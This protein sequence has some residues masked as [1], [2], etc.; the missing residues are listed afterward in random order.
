[1]KKLLLGLSCLLL[2]AM[3]QLA[4]A[5]P[6]AFDFLG[7]AMI[8]A[9]VGGSLSMY[10][11]VQEGSSTVVPP[12]PLDFINF[13][14]TIVVTDLVL[15]TDGTVQYYSNGA[16]ALYEDNGTV[17]DYANLATF[18]DG[19]PILTGVITTLSRSVTT[20]IFPPFATTITINGTVDWTGGTRLNEMAPAD[21]LNWSFLSAGNNDPADVMPGFTEQW[22][23]KVEPKEPIVGSDDSSF[24]DLKAGYQQ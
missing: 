20:A 5:Q 22:D 16:I 13:D 4:S 3:P 6:Q 1:M 12:L 19:T 10:S 7:Q 14:Y 8:P 2:I 17:A 21:Q 23:G 9:T 15:D 11:T 24:G 18:T